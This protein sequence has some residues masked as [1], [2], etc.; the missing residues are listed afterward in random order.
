MSGEFDC[1]KCRDTGRIRATI[2]GRTADIFCACPAGIDALDLDDSEVRRLSPPNQTPE[3]KDAID[4]AFDK[5][6]SVVSWVE[7]LFGDD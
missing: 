4:R 3:N 7:D 1:D 5:A 2:Q 6:D